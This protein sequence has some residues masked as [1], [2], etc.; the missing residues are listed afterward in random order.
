MDEE[1]HPYL[2]RYTIPV[3]LVCFEGTRT[4]NS[5]AVVQDRITGQT[6]DYST[7]HQDD[8]NILRR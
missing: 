5:P 2:K 4:I 7:N 6:Y 8:N 3:A 1:Y